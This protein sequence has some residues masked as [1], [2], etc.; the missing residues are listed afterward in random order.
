MWKPWRGPAA[1]AEGFPPA[2]LPAAG[3]CARPAGG[4]PPPPGWGAAGWLWGSVFVSAVYGPRVTPAYSAFSVAALGGTL[5]VGATLATGWWARR[6]APALSFGA[7]ASAVT[8][9]PTSNLAFPSGIVLA[10]RNLYLPVLLVAALTG[11]AV[12]WAQ[13]RWGA[14]PR[15]IG[16]VTAALAVVLGWRTLSR[17]PVWRENRT[18]L[19]TLLTE[20]PESYRGHWSAAAVLAGLGDTAA[21]RREDAR[22]GSLFQGDPH[23]HATHALFLLGLRDTAGARP[24]VERARQRLPYEP[25]AL[26]AQVLLLLLRGQ[27]AGATALADTARTQ[28]PWDASWYDAQ[29]R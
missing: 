13:G 12:Q 23:L 17:L 22:A 16:M 9:L 15:G 3:L 25:I 1:R 4:A 29:V 5:I 11:L 26:R 14:A 10:E 28:A 6:A 19:L 8:Y 18:F 21:A 20:H 27:R 7:W 2:A 24:L